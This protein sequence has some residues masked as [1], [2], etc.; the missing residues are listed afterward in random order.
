[1]ASLDR[2]RLIRFGR[3]RAAQGAGPVPLGIDIGTKLGT[4]DDLVIENGKSVTGLVVGVRGFLG[5]GEGYVV[6]APSTA[7]LNP[8]DG[9]R[10]AFVD[11]NRDT[12]KA[13]PKLEYR[14]R[15]PDIRLWQ[16]RGGTIRAAPFLVT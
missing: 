2:E 12:L 16:M 10:R 4:T 8:K 14:R 7:V 5:I 3:D 9:A 11:T 1:M 15:R 13:A 6:L